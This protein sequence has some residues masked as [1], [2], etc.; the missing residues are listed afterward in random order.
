MTR[1]SFFLAAALSVS[2][3]ACKKQSPVQGLD[4]TVAPAAPMATPSTAQV[5]AELKE[6]FSRVHFDFDSAALTAESVA[7][8]EANAALMVKHPAIQI[9]IQGHA[10]ERGTTEYNLALGQKRAEAVKNKMVAM[11][12]PRARLKVVSYGEEKP[13]VAGNGDVAWSANRRGEFRILTAEVA[14]VVGTTD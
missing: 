4:A 10:D 9:E 2:L 3:V 1:S 11:G 14:S 6:N 7:A 13:L 5:V 8:L 12:V